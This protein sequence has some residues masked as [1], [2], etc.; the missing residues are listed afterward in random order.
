M[1]YTVKKFKIEVIK[2]LIEDK[3]F[4]YNSQ[5]YKEPEVVRMINCKLP[6]DIVYAEEHNNGFIEVFRN[7]HV[8]SRLIKVY[9]DYPKKVKNVVVRMVIIP[10]N[11]QNIE[12]LR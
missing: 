3:S 8:I 2:K 11:S 5:E 4:Y 10:K 1:E 12:M 6:L 7:D 9:K